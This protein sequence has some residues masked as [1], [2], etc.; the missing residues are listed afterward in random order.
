MSDGGRRH[1]E[2]QPG[3]AALGPTSQ[4]QGAGS[5]VPRV[6]FFPAARPKPALPLA[7]HA[8][9]RCAPCL[10]PSAPLGPA[11]P[12]CGHFREP[13]NAP[14]VTYT[15]MSTPRRRFRPPASAQPH[16]T[17]RP[18]RGP[19]S[20]PGRRLRAPRGT[21]G[22]PRCTPGTPRCASGAWL[23][24]AET[25]AQPDFPERF[26]LR[27]LRLLHVCRQDVTCIFVV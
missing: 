3:Q 4:A 27:D 6:P 7:P 26:A 11:T 24:R 5:K 15:S 25:S 21:S 17:P 8:G 12:G 1:T 19:R 13:G 9:T 20:A 2:S 23:T 22:S 10:R 14:W 16:A 18:P